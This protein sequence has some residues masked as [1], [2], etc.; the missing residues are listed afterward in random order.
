[1]TSFRHFVM[2]V[3]PRTISFWCGDF[4][5]VI[6]TYGSRCYIRRRT[7]G[8][9]HHIHHHLL[10]LLV[11]CPHPIPLQS[12]LLS[13]KPLISVPSCHLQFKLIIILYQLIRECSQPML[14]PK[15]SI[16]TSGKNSIPLQD[17]PYYLLYHYRS[18]L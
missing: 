11:L 2:A 12:Y 4:R 1:M 13:L 8:L 5:L 10:H 14:K 16:L 17:E 3:V 9:H 15:I 7:C 6:I 18:S